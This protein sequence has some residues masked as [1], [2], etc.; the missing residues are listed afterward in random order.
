MTEHCAFFTGVP[1]RAPFSKT[2]R[3]GMERVITKKSEYGIRHR[4]GTARSSPCRTSAYSYRIYAVRG[5]AVSAKYSIGHILNRASKQFED[6]YQ[7]GA[8]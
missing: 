1:C 3:D 8:T 6:T 2:E 4:T 7:F 5:A